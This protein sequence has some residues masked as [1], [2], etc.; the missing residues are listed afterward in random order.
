MNEDWHLKRILRLTPD[1]VA[2]RMSAALATVGSSLIR[3]RILLEILS[4]KSGSC[5]VRER[6]ARRARRRT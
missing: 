3:L 2:E 5:R 4:N 6:Q 1:K